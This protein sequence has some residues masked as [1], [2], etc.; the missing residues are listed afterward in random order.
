[1]INISNRG[2]EICWEMLGNLGKYWFGVVD[3]KKNTVIGVNSVLDNCKNVVIINN[4]NF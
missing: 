3:L 2:G 4:L 1:M